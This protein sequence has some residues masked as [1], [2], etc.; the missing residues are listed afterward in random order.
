MTSIRNASRLG[1]TGTATPIGIDDY[2]LL[3][4]AT[5]RGAQALGMADEIGSLDVGKRADLQVIDRSL[6]G[7]AGLAGDADLHPGL[8]RHR[9]SHRCA[10]STRCV[11]RD[12]SS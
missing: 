8:H 3:E 11:Q 4:L 9:R 7:A 1:G 12:P 10:P 5:I 6:R 2:H